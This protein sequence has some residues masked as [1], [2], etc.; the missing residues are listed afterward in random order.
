MLVMS[1]AQQFKR[2]L[3]IYLKYMED[4]KD[5][6]DILDVLG[7][8][9]Q[10]LGCS[11]GNVT[12]TP[13][14]RDVRTHLYL[15]IYKNLQNLC[16]TPFIPLYSIFWITPNGFSSQKICKIQK[17]HLSKPWFAN[18]FVVQHS[19]WC[20]SEIS[21]LLSL[22]IIPIL[23]LCFLFP[24]PQVSSNSDISRGNGRKVPTM[25]WF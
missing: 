10:S 22:R 7:R 23:S 13:M 21:A 18:Y 11:P 14:F 12:T 2:S 6:S 19:T 8:A 17:M 20:N 16:D 9:T 24:M 15:K 4:P 5:P 25:C 1:N 3:P